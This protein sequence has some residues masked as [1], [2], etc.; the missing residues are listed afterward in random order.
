MSLCASGTPC[1]APS[2][3]PSRRRLSAASAAARAPSRSTSTKQFSVSRSRTMRSRQASVTSREVVLP[4]AIAAAVSAR[5]AVGQADD[6]RPGGYVQQGAAELEGIDIEVDLVVRSFDRAAQLLELD[7]QF[8]D[9]CSF[10]LKLG[11]TF[12][13]RT[14][15]VTLDHCPVLPAAFN[16]AWPAPPPRPRR[17]LPASY[18]RPWAGSAPSRRG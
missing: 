8:F 4:A 1:S 3:A 18:A 6:L 16:P 14:Y 12:V 2:G 17:P 11:V 13:H 10:E 9:A 5:D 7:R 15:K